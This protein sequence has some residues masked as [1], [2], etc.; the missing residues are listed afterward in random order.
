MTATDPIQ[1]RPIDNASF[2]A[3]CVF[4][5]AQGAKATVLAAEHNREALLDAFY[6]S[7]GLLLLE[8]MEGI[9]E[10]PTLLLRF[11]R[12]FGPE[13]EDYRQTLR[14]RHSIH[15]DVPEILLIAGKSAGA[16]KPPPRPDPPLTAEGKLPVQFPHRRGWHT[17]Q[18][19]RRP[20]P[21]MSLFL[22]VVPSP[23]D[24]GQTLFADG[25]A[26]YE[27]LP[28]DLK[29][30]VEDLEGLHVM[31]GAGRAEQDVRAGKTPDVLQSHERPQRQP[32]VRH[33]P[34]TGKRALYLCE[35]G[36]MDW[37]EGPL[38]GYEPGPDGEGATLLY[39]LMHH[40]T[41][42]DFTYAHHWNKGDL[43]I[44][45]NRSLIHSA[46]WYDVENHERVMWRTTVHG[47]PGAL[48]DGEAK[49]WIARPSGAS[50]L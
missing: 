23:R 37:I 40:F 36:Q 31:P 25:V 46:T 11:S 28:V 21:D 19:F 48:Y 14:A 49:S 32:V 8:G 47:N 6:G 35:A 33:H 41:G 9:A 7:G 22:A 20:P 42:P 5:G 50:F 1:L 3:C 34:V 18:S 16:V 15:P 13:V 29:A 27:A 10:D 26:A 43:V 12:L 45:D 24:Q 38:V 2:G 44:Y 39:R 4:D 30:L 17:D